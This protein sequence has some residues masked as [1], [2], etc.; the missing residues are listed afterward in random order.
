MNEVVP[1]TKTT[2][3]ICQGDTKI[4]VAS[5]EGFQIGDTVLIGEE[6]ARAFVGFGSL[7]LESP[8]AN[9]YPVGTVVRVIA[10]ISGNS[11]NST[12][13][14]E[15]EVITIMTQ[16]VP[17]G[18]TELPCKDSSKFHIGDQ[19]VI[20]GKETRFIV[21]F[22]S[23]FVDRPLLFSYPSGTIIKRLKS[24]GIFPNNSSETNLT[25]NVSNETIANVST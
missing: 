3:P 9:S 12:M 20:G 14:E 1:W 16:P 7:I 25:E 8:I 19:V 4:E 23:I 21:A 24:W 22:G 5:T 11:T 6:E 10:R 15:E 18:A 2:A 17:A 13:E